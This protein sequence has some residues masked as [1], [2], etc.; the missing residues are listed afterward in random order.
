MQ[1]WAKEKVSCVVVSTRSQQITRRA[2][3]L[4]CYFTVV[5]SRGEGLRN[6]RAAQSLCVSWGR[7]CALAGGS[8]LSQSTFGKGLTREGSLQE[9]LPAF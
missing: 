8:S 9:A 7:Q 5:M 4:K 1:E 2:L 3:E 6:S